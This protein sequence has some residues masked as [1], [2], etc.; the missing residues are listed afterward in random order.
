VLVVDGEHREHLAAHHVSE[1]RDTTGAGDTFNGALAAGLAAGDDVLTAARRAVV[2][3]ALS[4]AAVGARAG[5]PTAD[6]VEAALS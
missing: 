5:M 3:A 1:V 6:E 4:V 2:A